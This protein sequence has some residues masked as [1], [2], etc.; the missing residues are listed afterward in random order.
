MKNCIRFDQAS[1]ILSLSILINNTV[2]GPLTLL[3]F[4]GLTYISGMLKVY[5]PHKFWINLQILTIKF[6]HVNGS[7]S[8]ILTN[9]R[10]TPN[11]LILIFSKTRSTIVLWQ[12]ICFN[13]NSS[14]LSQI[15]WIWTIR[16]VGFQP[17]CNTALRCGCV[18]QPF[19]IFQISHNL[20]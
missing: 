16:N 9:L 12:T 15:S 6:G 14:F 5:S 10:I 11:F 17:V 7:D 1:M 18:T 3:K 19:L 20:S 13:Q 2:Y 4:T 8:V